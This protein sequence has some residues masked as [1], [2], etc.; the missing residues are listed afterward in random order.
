MDRIDVAIEL[1]EFQLSRPRRAALVLSRGTST[2][3]IGGISEMIEHAHGRQGAGPLLACAIESRAYE[4][5]LGG[6]V[7]LPIVLEPLR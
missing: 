1:D 4:V 2:P 5:G 7:R 3:A 6:G